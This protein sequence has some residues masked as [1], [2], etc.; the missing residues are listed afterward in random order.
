MRVLNKLIPGG[1][2]ELLAHGLYWSGLSSL[3]A[4]MPAKDSLL[5]LNYHRIGNPDE[6][7]FDPGV[8]SATAEQFDRQIG[9][10][11]QSLSPVTL[12]EALQFIEG[13][14]QK[15]ERRCRV[16]ITLDDGYLDNYKVAYPVL[17]AHGVQG[18]FFL[19]TS[20]VGTSDLPWWDHIAYLLK[21][22]RRRQFSLSYPDTLDV[23]ID[24]NGLEKSL[25]AVLRLYKRPENVDS[26]RFI[27]EFAC[28]SAGDPPPQAQRRFLDWDEAR[29][30]IN[31]GMAIGSHTHS[32]NL[33][34]QLDPALQ[35]RELV[36]SRAILKEKLGTEIDTLS[37]PVG[38][39]ASFT[40]VTQQLAQEAGYRAAFSY[41]GGTNLPGK[42]L[43]SD[44]K[45]V[46]IDDHSFCRFRV[47]CSVCKLT[48]HFE[49]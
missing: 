16:L 38:G 45:R 26:E 18:V 41:H 1:K 19:A 8:F 10:I 20:M 27:R 21:T 29:E 24:G 25:V 32:H 49:P 9:F 37:Y 43:P 44:V 14:E 35:R 7:L 3:M 48:A 6:D 12:E 28:A 22:A 34:S 47:Q 33:L 15:S 39:K 5:V 4:R 13:R 30:M 2:R 46:G 40:Q 11:K 17:R 31:G 23:D 42:T 36:L